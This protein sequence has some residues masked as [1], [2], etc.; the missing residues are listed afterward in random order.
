ML[1]TSLLWRSKVAF[2]L[3]VKSTKCLCLLPMVYLVLLFQSWSWSYEFGFVYITDTCTHKHTV[4]WTDCPTHK[5]PYLDYHCPTWQLNFGFNQMK[6]LSV[7]C[8]LL[9]KTEMNKTEWWATTYQ[10]QQ[11]SVKLSG[12]E[13]KRSETQTLRTGCSKAEP[14]IF[15]P[16]HT[17]DT[18]FLGVQD[19][20]YLISWRWS[21]PL[22]TNPV[23]WGSM[24]AI[25]SYRGNR[26]THKQNH[27]QGRLQYT[28]P[29][30]LARS[31]IT[32]P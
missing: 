19:G 2:H 16:P 23:W 4:M 9:L 3:K 7:C 10:M 6:T 11:I 26:S 31:V 27:R 21:L 13:K 20:Q 30:S 32:K 5:C 14:K 1:G 22:P 29:L 12:N 25:L 24:H 15:T 8:S 18:P 28:A 17:R